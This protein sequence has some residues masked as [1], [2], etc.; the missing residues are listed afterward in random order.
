[1]CLG[2]RPV[3]QHGYNGTAFTAQLMICRTPGAGVVS[4]GQNI[5]AGTPA[6]Q[7]ASILTNG[8]YNNE[9]MDFPGYGSDNPDMSK[10]HS[11]GHFSQMVWKKTE[12]VGCYTA[13]CSP[14]GANPQDCNPATGQSYLKDTNCGRNGGM[15][16]IFTVCNY[17]PP[18]KLLLLSSSTADCG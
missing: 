16:A 2:P 17:S 11:W 3:S 4:Y 10:W 1:M 13:V 6:G 9:M 18:G 15:A 14:P 7:I 8:F 12:K 5:A